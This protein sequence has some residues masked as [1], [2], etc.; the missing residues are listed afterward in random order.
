[1]YKLRPPLNVNLHPV[2]VSSSDE[3]YTRRLRA[4]I[5]GLIED[6]INPQLRIYE[7]AGVQL[8]LDVWERAV[9]QRVGEDE[10]VN[11]I[12]VEQVRHSALTIGLL[13]DELRPGTKEEL[14]AAIE[15]PEV[16]VAIHI[17]DRPEDS[18]DARPEEVEE[19]LQEYGGKIFYDDRCGPPD[20]DTAWFSLVRTLLGF[21]FAA[22]RA[23]DPRARTVQTEVR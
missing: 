8:A 7:E 4:R 21:T 14:V 18:A 15:Q 19:F 11:D 16:Q 3:D 6:V 20:G 22:M 17:F 12:F 10:N 2:F 5:K 9:P 23:N 1:M 13:L